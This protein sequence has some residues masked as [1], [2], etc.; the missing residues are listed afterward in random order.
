MRRNVLLILLAGLLAQGLRLSGHH[1]F[2]AT[3]Y[4]DR[5]ITIQG[6]L[7]QF[8]F[9]NPHSFVYVMAPDD[10]KQMQRW[11]AEWAGGGQLAR[12]GMTR[13][14]LKRGDIVSIT[15]APGRNEADHRLRMRMIVRPKDGF[16]WQ[17]V[18]D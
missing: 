13:D 3:Y 11:S 4:E 18:V 1:S 16:K 2:A 7:V 6:E 14:T 15:G 8:Q 5:E 17:G 12:Q 10:K 9:R